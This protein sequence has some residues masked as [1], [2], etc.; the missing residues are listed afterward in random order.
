MARE[1]DMRR[2][3]S[4]SDYDDAP[5]KPRTISPA[6]NKTAPTLAPSSAENDGNATLNSNA[7]DVTI[8]NDVTI[9][10]A[11]LRA[12]CQQAETARADLDND[13]PVGAVARS[14]WQEARRAM[15]DACPDLLDH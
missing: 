10:L 11:S 9:R 5:A 4:W 13:F 2:D 1:E 6:E 8:Q 14:K 15:A 3:P 7:G 12:L